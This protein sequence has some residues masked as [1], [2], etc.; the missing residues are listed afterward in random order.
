MS[1]GRCYDISGQRHTKDM[2]EGVESAVVQKLFMLSGYVNVAICLASVGVITC[3][4]QNQHKAMITSLRR[5][6]LSLRQKL[7][8]IEIRSP[9]LETDA[10]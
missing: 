6:H 9:E 1:V 8:E 5:A 2:E 10:T 4:C 3:I 7:P